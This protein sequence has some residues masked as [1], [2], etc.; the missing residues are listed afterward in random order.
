MAKIDNTVYDYYL[1]T[2]GDHLRP[3]KYDTHKKSELRDT[4]NK[5]IKTNKNSPLVKINTSGEDLK[6]FAID[7]KEQARSAQSVI[8]SI[9]VDEDGIEN[10]F[11]KKV[12]VSSNKNAVNVEYVGEDDDR[13]EGSSEGFKIGVRSL[14]KPQINTGYFLRSAG[15]DFESGDFSF[16]LHTPS[17]SYEFQLSL[18]GEET[19]IDVQNKI[20]RLVNTSDV[21]LTARV[22]QN[23]RGQSALQLTSKQTG[24]AEGE[25]YLFDLKSQ[26]SPEALDRLGINHITEAAENSSFTLN[27]KEHSSLSNTFTI[28]KEFEIS[29]QAPTPENED[30][31]IGFKTN[32]EAVSDSVQE[33]IDSFNGMFEVGRR[34]S[35][36]HNNSRLMNEVIGIQ[37]TM[38]EDLS[39]VG[40]SISEEGH[41]E[42]DREKMDEA[43]APG[44]ADETFSVLNRFKN[45]MARQAE[46]I[47]INPISYVD[48][49]VVEY[50]NP[51]KTF[52]APYAQSAYAGLLLDRHL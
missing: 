28:N 38:E 35:E 33:I 45:T 16:D 37:N 48:S 36:G 17:N 50:K 29:L 4:Y 24:L 27:G 40:I 32:T 49:L 52:S 1:T 42:L 41:F 19:N 15:K 14:A 7:L 18:S 22:L 3:T 30:A 31:A 25:D 12:A 9:S 46:K 26:T 21:G 43:L 5:I 39:R 2:Y 8:A 51:G 6:K 34:Y 10:V 20:A 23:E 44:A 11:H 47:A 13:S